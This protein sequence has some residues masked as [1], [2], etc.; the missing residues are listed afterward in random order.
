MKEPYECAVCG[1]K[2]PDAY[3]TCNW[4]G[5]LDGRDQVIHR[6]PPYCPDSV[7]KEGGYWGWAIIMIVITWVVLLW[8]F[9]QF[10]IAA[11]GY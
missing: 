5:C 3:V 10:I 9:I 11:T 6:H 8:G 2:N 1:S 4:G 7:T